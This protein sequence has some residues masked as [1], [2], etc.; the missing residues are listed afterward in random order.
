MSKRIENL[1]AKEVAQIQRGIDGYINDN[2]E[3]LRKAAYLADTEDA[4]SIKIGK[5]FII[6]SMFPE[7]FGDVS[8]DK[9]KA[10][11]INE[12]EVN[13]NDE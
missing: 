13:D 3:K 9:F 8:M 7:V 6:C 1:S 11:F 4:L 5:A 12:S 10:L 2:A